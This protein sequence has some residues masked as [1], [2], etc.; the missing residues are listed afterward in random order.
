VSDAAKPLDELGD[1]PPSVSE[2]AQTPSQTSSLLDAVLAISGDLDLHTTLQRIVAAAARLVDA[3]YA[4]LGVIDRYGAGLSEFVTFG[5]TAAETTRIGAPPV[6]HGLLGLIIRERRP[7]RVGDL[8]SSPETHGFPANHPEMTSLL[9]VP[10]WVGDQVFG[11]LYLTDKRD[12]TDFTDA[13]E[14]AVIALAQAAGAAVNNARRYGRAQQRERWMAATAETL[15]LLLGHVDR[16]TILQQVTARAREVAGAELALALLEQSDGSLLVEAADGSRADLLDTSPALDGTL[17]DVVRRGATVHLSEGVRLPG[18]EGIASALLV[19]FSGPGG[20]GGALLVGT[21]D[22]LSYR[23]LGEDDVQALR[24]FAAQ[25]ALALDRAQAQEDR[26]TLAILADRDRIARD[27][28]D[29]VIQRLFAAGLTLQ[30]AI[31]RV[32]D[33]SLADRLRQ[34][35]DDLDATIH[36]I[37]G[38]IFELGQS[39]ASLDIRAQIRAVAA[40]VEPVLR[41]RPHVVMDGPLESVVPLGVRP[42]LVAV[43]VEALSNAAR[44]AA[45]SAVE[46]LVQLTG[47]GATTTLEVIVRDDGQGFASVP[48]ESGLRNMRERAK[49]LGGRFEVES[50]PGAGTCVSWQVPVRE[51]PDIDTVDAHAASRALS[52][53]D[54]NRAGSV[55]N[56]S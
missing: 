15:R 49:A 6:G 2:N 22:P 28:H 33:R 19:P 13:D 34:T 43:L 55:V 8:G 48:R 18:L 9:G 37:R 45:A 7:L 31:R 27:L 44:H 53:D 17:A 20:A 56:E 26:A 12:G 5:L 39:D 23:E 40:S 50:S 4:A 29:V 42:H 14:L 3:R 36:D 30:S 11:N 10:V 1:R 51:R 35:I 38:T 54:E 32:D 21:S 16:R 24:G 47:S 46:V 41:F 25:V 52:S